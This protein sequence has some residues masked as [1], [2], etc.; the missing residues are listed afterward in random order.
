MG[1][2]IKPSKTSQ[3]RWEDTTI[4]QD[5]YITHRN[6][7]S[8]LSQMS[9]LSMLSHVNLK[10]ICIGPQLRHEVTS[11]VHHFMYILGVFFAILTFATFLASDSWSIHES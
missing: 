7:C 4:L 6:S 2:G 11:Y 9:P 5:Y 1:V 3:T 10:I 8:D